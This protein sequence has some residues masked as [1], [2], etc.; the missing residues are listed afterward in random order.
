MQLYLQARLFIHRL[1]GLRL[2]LQTV[3]VV[4]AFY[5]CLSRVSDYKHH[6]TDVIAGAVIGLVVALFTVCS[7]LAKLL[8]ILACNVITPEFLLF[9][10]IRPYTVINFIDSWQ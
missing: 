4:G 10:N 8:Q 9:L 2:A 7:S 3:V 1:R 6:P 5:C